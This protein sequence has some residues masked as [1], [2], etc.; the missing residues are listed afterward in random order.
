MRNRHGDST[1]E[2][3]SSFEAYER[4]SRGAPLDGLRLGERVTTGI[5]PTVFEK[6]WVGLHVT[7]PLAFLSHRGPLQQFRMAPPRGGQ[8]CTQLRRPAESCVVSL[9]EAQRMDRRIVYDPAFGDLPRLI[10]FGH[11]GVSYRIPSLPS[12]GLFG[13]HLEITRW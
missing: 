10:R 12:L 8:P 6:S 1:A 2:G 13:W 4:Q 9:T 7:G 3:H 5:H 11:Q